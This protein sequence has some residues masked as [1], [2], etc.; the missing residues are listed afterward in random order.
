MRTE[1]TC[2]E[3]SCTTGFDGFHHHMLVE[4]Y[5]RC[6]VCDSDQAV[7]IQT[8]YPDASH[9]P[10]FALGQIAFT[11]GVIALDLGVGRITEILR[12]HA[13]GDWGSVD[14]HDVKVN[15]GA[16]PDALP[17]GDPAAVFSRQRVLSRW[18]AGDSVFWVITEA[19]RHATTF[20]LPEEY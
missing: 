8:S 4:G 12:A 5:P 7:E 9:A 14:A 17:D 18:S 13:S 11:P 6:P 2:N 20:L 10:R 16:I 1:I 15:N 3:A 19:G